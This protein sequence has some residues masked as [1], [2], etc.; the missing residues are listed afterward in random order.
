MGEEEEGEEGAMRRSG[1]LNGVGSR[2]L[3]VVEFYG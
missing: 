3:G 2:W 1:R